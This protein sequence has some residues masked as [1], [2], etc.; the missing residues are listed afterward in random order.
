MHLVTAEEMRLLD[1]ATIE[2]GRASGE[3]LMERAGAGVVEA[4]E[5]TYGSL[6]AMRV[7]V[8]CGAGNNGGDGFVAA[9]HLQRRGAEGRVGLVGDPATVTGGAGANPV[10][11][12]EAGLEPATVASAGQPGAPLAAYDSWGFPLDA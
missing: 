9:R 12:R 4:I 7:L 8:L 3:I 11:L 1:R 10:R 6:L 5:R 2:T